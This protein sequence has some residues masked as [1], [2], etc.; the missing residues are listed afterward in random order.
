M[1]IKLGLNLPDDV[2]EKSAHGFFTLPEALILPRL[3][4]VIAKEKVMFQV[5]CTSQQLAGVTS[6]GCGGS[7]G[8]EIDH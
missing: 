5:R 6:L 8:L 2:L 4:R 3:K 1:F 7:G